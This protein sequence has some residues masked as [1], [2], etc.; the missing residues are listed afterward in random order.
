MAA[1]QTSSRRRIRIRVRGV[2]QGVGFRPYVYR[3]ASGLDLGGSVL[4]DANGVLIEVE[5]D[6][7]RI[8]AFVARLP[9]DAPPLASVEETRTD[10]L[11]PTGEDGFVVA[12]S[13]V[14]GDPDA[15]VSADAAT[16]A[17]CLAELLD[18]RDRR[19]RYPFLNCTNCGPRF[20]IVRDV[21]YDRPATTMSGFRDVPP[22][23]GRVRGSDRPPLPCP[24]QCLSGLR[25]ARCGSSI[26]RRAAVRRRG[27]CARGTRRRRCTR[28]GS[29]P[30]RESAAI[31]SP[32]AA[33]DEA[34][35]AKL[36]SRKHREDRPFALMVGN[37]EAARE[38]VELTAAEEAL[39]EGRERPIVIARRRAGAGV[40]G[41]VAPEDA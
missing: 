37:L 32:R 11:T 7:D 23:P 17:D 13:V 12:S 40:A 8:E 31:T 16:C 35:V 15:L 3:L 20:T 22:L 21:P 27:C 24:A 5:G 39:L 28:A 33:D 30:S 1:A 9:V 36:R 25:S 38:L 34:V 18:P 41:S 2:V 19:F 29:S 14:G 10:E 6:P 4:N 26:R